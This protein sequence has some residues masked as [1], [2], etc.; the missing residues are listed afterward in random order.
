MTDLSNEPLKVVLFCDSDII[1]EN[2]PTENVTYELLTHN[3][4]DEGSAIFNFSSMKPALQLAE[5]KD[6]DIV[7]GISKKFSRIG[8]AGRKSEDK[9][10]EL[11][12]VH[13]LA[14][15]V[16]EKLVQQENTFTCFKS[17]V[18]SDI[19]DKIVLKNGSKIKDY[20]PGKEA[21]AGL[22]EEENYLLID[23]YH[24]FK[25]SGNEDI[26]YYASLIVDL[27]RAQQKE[28]LTVADHLVE[29]YRQ[30]GYFREKSYKVNLDFNNQKAY[31]D[32]IFKELRKSP[33][34]KIGFDTIVNI[35]DYHKQ[36]SINLLS[37]KK[38]AINTATANILKLKLSGGTTVTLLQNSEEVQY[39]ISV[40]GNLLEK[41]QLEEINKQSDDLILKIVESLNK[42][43]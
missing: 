1:P 17:P 12:N 26:F 10:L 18:F 27:A 16:L 30:Y 23:E 7:L 3:M 42:L 37:G 31:F 11:Y 2:L 13:Q 41:T 19:I 5:E 21:E 9:K 14:A 6:Y 39:Y 15:I 20:I 38:Y 40:T 4:E 33:P 28:S 29:L 32:R 24:T 25:Y 8:L 36:V 43:Y 35:T 22:E 34:E